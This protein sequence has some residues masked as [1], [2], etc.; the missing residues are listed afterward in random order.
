MPYAAENQISQSPIVG[1]IEITEQQYA[2]ALEG[3]L[4]GKVITIDGGFAVIDPPKPE[5]PEPETSKSPSPTTEE[6][7]IQVRLQ[8]DALLAACDWVVVRSQELGEPVPQEWASYRQALR[9]I[10]E[11]P[12]FPENV[13]WPE[14]PKSGTSAIR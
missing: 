9:D 2:D 13:E 1:G 7:A 14:P 11:Q 4:A 5:E 12:G 3:M 6:K 10:P 8:R